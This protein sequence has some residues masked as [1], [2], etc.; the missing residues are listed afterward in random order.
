M[1]TAVSVHRGNP[2][3]SV[4][5]TQNTAPVHEFRCLYTRDLHKKAKKWHDG[6]LRF[7]TFNRRVMVY[8]DAKN[9]IGDLHYT[10]EEEFGEGVEIQL[11]RG[12]KVEVG[13][14]LGE[15]ETDLAPI[16]ER[17][18]PEKATPQKRPAGGFGAQSLSSIPSQ[19]PKSLLEVLGPSQGRLGR[20]RLPLQSPYEQRQATFRPEPNEPPPKRRRLSNDKENRPGESVRVATPSKPCIPQPIRSNNLERSPL[21][22]K[23]PPTRPRPVVEISSDEE[24]DHDRRTQSRTNVVSSFEPPGAIGRSQ[25]A[26]E[27]TLM[28]QERKWSKTNA[29]KAQTT[30]PTP[31]DTTKQLVTEPKTG[32]ILTKPRLSIQRKARL[33][34]GRPRPKSKLL[35]LQP[36]QTPDL[37]L[38][39]GTPVERASPREEARSPTPL[40]PISD[41]E[42]DNVPHPTYRESPRHP[43]IKSSPRQATAGSN[44]TDIIASSPL[45]L[46]EDGNREP[47]LPTPP[48]MPTQEEFPFLAMTMNELEQHERVE[49]NHRNFVLESTSVEER[50]HNVPELDIAD[51]FSSSTPPAEALGEAQPPSVVL[52]GPTLMPHTRDFRRVFSENDA[53]VEDDAVQNPGQTS[54]VPRS[55]LK[56]LNDLSTRQTSVK[57]KSPQKFQRCASDTAALKDPIEEFP[58]KE[59]GQDQEGQTGPW[60]S[61]EAFLLFDWWPP[62]MEKPE[63]WAATVEK[64]SAPV[65]VAAAGGPISG[66]PSMITTARQFLRDDANA[67]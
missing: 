10:K 40:P 33:L 65:A 16:L 13:E 46:P 42:L 50:L 43:N 64:P 19:R 28:L 61:D 23:A 54:L 39:A 63:Y 20:S 47:R 6:S 57:S 34:L 44:G 41:D 14:R 38:H 59:H 31:R 18:R 52:T 51:L 66:Y 53:V 29:L 22:Q 4:A 25:R 9:Y 45:F 48:P 67:L 56:I 17:Q 32:A 1:V 30:R 60:T 21:V 26:S 58:T 35:V 15:T 5:P 7:H 37:R 11:D 24:C 27:S 49:N 36:F 2:T 12:V 62:G 8:D 3:L 55:P